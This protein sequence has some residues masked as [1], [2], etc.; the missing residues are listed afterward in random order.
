MGVF[1]EQKEGSK[2]SL[3]DVLRP[4]SEMVAA[5]YT[6]YGSSCNLVLSTGHGVNGFTLD[7]V[8]FPLRSRLP[9]LTDSNLVS[10]RIHPHPPGY[11]N[12]LARQDLLVQRRKLAPLPRT[13]QKVPRQH[14]VPGRRQALQRAI[15]WIHGR[16]RPPNITLRRNLWLPR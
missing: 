4:G 11:P 15:H 1:G 10:R 2:G 14:Q 9:L 16:R 13:H 3:S 6:M 8:S 7:E 12:S 5:G